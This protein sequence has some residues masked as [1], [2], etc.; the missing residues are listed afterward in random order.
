MAKITSSIRKRLRKNKRKTS[1]QLGQIMDKKIVK[2]KRAGIVEKYG[3]KY[4]KLREAEF[5]EI[6]RAML[7]ETND[8]KKKQAIRRLMFKG[9]K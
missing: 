7:R 2:R 5:N 3:D 1:K 4:Q 8:P 6:F 9:K